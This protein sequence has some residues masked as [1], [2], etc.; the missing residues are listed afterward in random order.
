ME[1]TTVGE[2]GGSAARCHERPSAANSHRPGLTT[3][4]RFRSMKLRYWVSSGGRSAAKRISVSRAYRKSATARA[5]SV[6]MRSISSVARLSRASTASLTAILPVWS[7]ASTALREI[8]VVRVLSASPSSRDCIQAS[9]A[10]RT[11][12]NTL[13][14]AKRLMSLARM[15]KPKSASFF[16][17]RVIKGSRFGSTSGTSMWSQRGINGKN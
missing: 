6:L 9:R 2:Y 11:R 17:R 14:T 15:P 7:R 4:P 8:S 16:S 1:E 12:G 13:M 10:S 5:A 3:R